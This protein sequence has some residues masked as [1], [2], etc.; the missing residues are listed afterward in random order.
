M[1]GAVIVLSLIRIEQ[2][3]RIGQ[4]DKFS[5]LLAYGAL[6]YWWG[7]VRPDQRWVWAVALP[8]MGLALEWLQGLT[9][10]RQMEWQDALAN[11]GG[12]ALALLLLATPA[13][14]LLAWFD[15]QL[16]DG[17]DTGGP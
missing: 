5:H 4:G 14:R 9:P 6:M 1:L 16:G 13:R 15:R 11:L 2:P 8:L 10:Y 3:V 12:V 7:M 17:F